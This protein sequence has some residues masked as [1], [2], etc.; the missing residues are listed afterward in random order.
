[1]KKI[2][3]QQANQI[4]S[5]VHLKNNLFFLVLLFVCL[6]TLS[7]QAQKTWTGAT[8][9]DWHTDTNWSPVGVP[10]EDDDVIIPDAINDPVITES[11]DASTSNL[12]I[13]NNGHLTNNSGSAL[14]VYGDLLI[15]AGGTLSGNGYYIM[16]GN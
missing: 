3:Y 2:S 5:F 6:C 15:E 14:N 1:M 9:T 7:L 13:Y 8:S 10:T 4:D 11:L 12:T 16:L